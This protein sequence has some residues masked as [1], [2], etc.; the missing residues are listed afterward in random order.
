M[1]FYPDYVEAVAAAC[2]VTLSS[3]GH[4]LRSDMIHYTVL[5]RSPDAVA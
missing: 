2:V 1:G 3:Q 5:R 4:M